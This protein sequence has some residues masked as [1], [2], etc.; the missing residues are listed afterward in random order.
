MRSVFTVTGPNTGGLLTLAEAKAALGIDSLDVSRD[1]DLNRL[2]ARIS[3]S[4]FRACKLTGDGVNPTTLLSEEITE[5]FRLRSDMTGPLLLSRKRVTEIGG[6][7]IGETALVEDTDF[8]VNRA[9]GMIYGLN[10]GWATGSVVIDYVAGL[11]TV[12]ADLKLAAELWLRALWRDH[13][14]SPETLLD[15]LIKTEDI[16]GVRRIERW[17]QGMAATAGMSMVPPEVESIL[18]EGGYVEIWIA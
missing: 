11:E 10:G 1:A 12:P 9:A 17:V 14:G 15:P 3:Q 7:A 2:I 8:E 18:Y 13:Y 5:T 6:L 16:P 4:M